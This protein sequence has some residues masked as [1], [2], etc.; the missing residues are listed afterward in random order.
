[1]HVS[2]RG[3]SSGKQHRISLH[4]AFH[5]MI[6]PCEIPDQLRSMIE[7]V[8]EKNSPACRTLTN[9]VD[10][11]TKGFIII[12]L[13][14]WSICITFNVVV[15][16]NALFANEGFEIIPVPFFICGP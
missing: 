2:D 13:V 11:F 7:N 14:Y 5:Q 9:H 15:K 10:I 16:W 1:M 8:E 3:L 4:K 6:W 12:C